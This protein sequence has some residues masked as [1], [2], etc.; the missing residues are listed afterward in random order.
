MIYTRAEVSH[1]LTSRVNAEKLIAH[2]PPAR[3]DDVIYLDYADR[4]FPFGLTLLWG[5]DKTD[6]AAVFVRYG[7][8]GDLRPPHSFDA[9]NDTA[10]H[11]SGRDAS[12]RVAPSARHLPHQCLAGARGGAGVCLGLIHGSSG[13]T[14]SPDRHSRL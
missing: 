10:R 6:I 11:R 5:D 3:W 8:F 9:P 7:A 1:F 2:I 13:R 14:P 12:V 4:K